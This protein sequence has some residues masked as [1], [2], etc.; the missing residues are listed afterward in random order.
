MKFLVIVSEN[1]WVSEN[2]L[3]R[4]HVLKTQMLPKTKT[5]DCVQANENSKQI[6]SIIKSR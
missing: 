3:K 1:G 4:K 2:R 5:P 6:T